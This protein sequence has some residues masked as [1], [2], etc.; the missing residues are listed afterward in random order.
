MDSTD[1][2][3]QAREAA[4]SNVIAQIGTGLIELD[5]QSFEQPPARAA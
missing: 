3:H 4:F 1:E 5:Y 2:L